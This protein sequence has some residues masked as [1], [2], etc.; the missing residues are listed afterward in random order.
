MRSLALDDPA[1]RFLNA[2]TVIRTS[3]GLLPDR[4][5]PESLAAMTDERM[6]GIARQQT[7]VELQVAGRSDEL[8][9]TVRVLGSDGYGIVAEAARGPYKVLSNWTLDPNS[10]E[11][12]RRQFVARPHRPHLRERLQDLPWRLVFPTHCQLEILAIE[13]ADDAQLAPAEPWDYRQLPNARGLRWLVYGDSLTQGANVS[14]A[15]GTWVDHTAR[16][17]GLRST[18]LAIGGFGAAKWPVAQELARRA[19][20]DV[21]SLHMGADSS[22]HRQFLHDCHRFLDHVRAAHPTVPILLVSPTAHHGDLLDGAA[23]ALRLNQEVLVA[24]RRQQG[25]DRLHFL[26]GTELL[27]DLTRGFNF[28]VVHYND[29]GAALYAHHFTPH[30]A[31]LC[32]EA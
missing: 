12:Q 28:D 26:S 22:D 5:H 11:P 3:D 19:D 21:L 14:A 29:Y 13:V 2:V 4:Y 8:A 32:D 27:P 24:E 1:I 7:S 18:N 23:Q 9:V 17:L 30:L 15:C 16:T 6:A 20:F 25:D 31:R 10:R